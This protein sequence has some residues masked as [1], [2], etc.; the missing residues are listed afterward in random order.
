MKKSFE[1]ES[2]CLD[3][4]SRIKS[5][6]NDYFVMYNLDKNKFELHNHSQLKNT[7]C[8]TFPFE[9]LDERAY[10]HTLKTRV[11]NSDEIFAKID[12]FNKQLEKEQT[13]QVLKDFEEK[14]YDSY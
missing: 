5:I 6:D 9:T 13:K 2:D 10:I 1:I 8:L 14:I 12:E 3:I 7:Y 11:Q 4:V